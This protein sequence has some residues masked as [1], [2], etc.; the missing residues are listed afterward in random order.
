MIRS[1]LRHIEILEDLNFRQF[2]SQFNSNVPITE[3]YN[4]YQKTNNKVEKK[5]EQIGSLKSNKE[6]YRKERYTNEEI[7]KMSPEE[8]RKNWDIV[9]KSM[10]AQD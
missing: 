7:A 4:L 8:I 3:I 2:S 1:A 10:T 9:R 5:Y 6:P